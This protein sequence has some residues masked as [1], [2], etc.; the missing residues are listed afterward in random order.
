[1]FTAEDHGVR[2]R[3]AL[4][5]AGLSALSVAVAGTAALSYRANQMRVLGPD[6]GQ[7]FD[8]W[9]T[10]RDDPG[11]RG[12]IAAAVLAPSPH[13]TQPWTFRLDGTRIALR[14]DPARWMRNVDPY[15]REAHAALGCALENLVLGARA[16]GYH[17]RVTLLPDPADPNLIAQLDLASGPAVSSPLYA[18]IGRRRS[19]RGPYTSRAVPAAALDDL[20]ALPEGGPATVRFVTDPAGRAE[21]GALLVQGAR[22]LSADN[23]QSLDGYAWLRSTGEQIER[24]KDGLTL[25]TQGLS[26][27]MT[28]VAKLMPAGSRAAGDQFWI[29]QTAT[30]HTPTAAAYGFVLVPDPHEPAHQVAGGRLLQR[31]HLAATTRGLAFQHMNQVSERIDRDVSQGRAPEFQARLDAILAPPPGRQVVAT[32]RLGYPVRAVGRSPRRPV[33][34]VTT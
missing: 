27:L 8:A 21:F 9:R 22:A 14:S 20:T 17:P 2:R 32:F 10:W 6:T 15:R 30:V 24:H 33:S 7:A 18:A 34:E 4:R 1:M 28:T 19:N 12:A 13:N 5:V 25:D 26:L 29:E 16:R 31:L 23:A 3:E 11:P